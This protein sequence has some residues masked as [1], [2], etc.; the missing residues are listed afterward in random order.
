MCHFP[1]LTWEHMEKNS[2]MIHG[3]CH[4]K[5]D[6]INKDSKALRVDIGLDSEF[7]NYDL[8]SLEKLAKYFKKIEDDNN[9]E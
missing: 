2:V 1:L 4:G 6:K 5:I 9:L 8:V 7:A 3:H